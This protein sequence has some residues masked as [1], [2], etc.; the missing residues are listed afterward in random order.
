MLYIYFIYI[1]LAFSYLTMT[2]VR[3][4][5]VFLQKIPAE[6]TE[7]DILDYLVDF[8]E[9]IEQVYITHDK[10][11]AFVV[12]TEMVLV[13][14]VVQYT[15]KSLLQELKVKSGKVSSDDESVLLQL[16]DESQGA[17]GGVSVVQPGVKVSFQDVL[18]AL[19]RMN[20]EQKAQIASILNPTVSIEGNRTHNN[21]THENSKC[22]TTT[23]NCTNWDTTNCTYAVKQEVTHATSATPS[24][25][26]HATQA[27][28]SSIAAAQT[29]NQHNMPQQLSSQQ[30]VTQQ[31]QVYTGFP[32][33]SAFHTLII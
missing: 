8:S 32:R 20:P 12:L 3:D 4:R 11:G 13:S 2:S 14:K 24:I 30:S 22:C 17:T 25:R 16:I 1:F 23:I 19:S 10:Y 15:K 29:N 5:T 6:V 7:Q 9:S 28:T 18:L 33:V 21:C 27:H 26:Q 31:P